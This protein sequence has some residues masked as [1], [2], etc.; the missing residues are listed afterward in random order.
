MYLFVQTHDLNSLLLLWPLLL[1]LNI[2]LNK[3]SLYRQKSRSTTTA[4]AKRSRRRRRRCRCRCDDAI[5]IHFH[6]LRST[7]TYTLALLALW[8]RIRMNV[9]YERV[10]LSLSDDP[11]TGSLSV[12]L[13]GSLMIHRKRRNHGTLMH[14]C[15]FIDT[16]A[17]VCVL[18][19]F[20]HDH[21]HDNDDEKRAHLHAHQ[22]CS[23]HTWR[24]NRNVL[25]VDN[26]S[27][28]FEWTMRYNQMQK[29]VL[30]DHMILFFRSYKSIFSSEFK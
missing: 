25:T 26:N 20:I 21:D 23:A 17:N 11:L 14:T 12:W 7:H 19:V 4:T 27:M 13:V 2:D 3:R 6:L 29:S 1:C 5:H 24:R 9:S 18:S 22:L 28:I 10:E 30:S 8:F 15:A 16:H